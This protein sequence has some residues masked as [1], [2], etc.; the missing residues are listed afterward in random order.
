MAKKMLLSTRTKLEEII[1][2]MISGKKRCE[3]ITLKKI[4]PYYP[5]NVSQACLEAWYSRTN[6]FAN[7]RN[8]PTFK[9]KY[10][11]IKLARRDKIKHIAEDNI[12]LAISG[13]MQIADKDLAD[14][15]LKVIEKIDDDWNP[16]KDINLVSKNLNFNISDE[17]LMARIQ[18]LTNE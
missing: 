12:D 15:S 6:F 8:H 14:F 4:P 17:E 7:L 11:D 1:N 16:K 18:E 9:E 10:E 13:K 5:L 3:H 2:L